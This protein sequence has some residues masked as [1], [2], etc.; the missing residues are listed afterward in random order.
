MWAAA[1]SLASTSPGVHLRWDGAARPLFAVTLYMLSQAAG[2][3]VGWHH[4]VAHGRQ[5]TFWVSDKWWVVYAEP[6]SARLD[7]CIQEH[8]QEF[9]VRERVL[10][11]ARV[12]MVP[13][14]HRERAPDAEA[15]VESP[16]AAR[17]VRRS[18]REWLEPDPVH[19]AIPP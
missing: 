9:N 4:P 14:L 17:A 7:Y 13:P 1:L 2:A 11:P 12:R 6:R 5:V 3:D 16:R 8:D 19:L 18:P 15:S 10:A